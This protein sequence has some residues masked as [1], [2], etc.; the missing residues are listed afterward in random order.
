MR[1]F[2]M[3][4]PYLPARCSISSMIYF[5]EKPSFNSVY[6]SFGLSIEVN[7]IY[8]TLPVLDYVCNIYIYRFLI[9]WSLKARSSF[10]AFQFML[11]MC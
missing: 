5:L 1:V 10:D 9:T 4:F 8:L 2:S 3:F 7:L 6:G 11:Q